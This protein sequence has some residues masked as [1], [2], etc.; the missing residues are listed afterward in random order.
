MDDMKKCSKCK[1]DCLK[2]NFYKD[3]TRKHGSRI[4]CKFCTNR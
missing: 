3:T 2:I 4:Y 1:I